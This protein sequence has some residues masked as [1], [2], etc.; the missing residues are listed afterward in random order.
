MMQTDRWITI[1]KKLDSYPWKTVAW[2]G[3]SCK[4]GVLKRLHQ[5]LANVPL[6]P[7][8]LLCLICADY[9]VGDIEIKFAVICSPSYL[10]KSTK[11]LLTCTRWLEVPQQMNELSVI[12]MGNTMSL[13]SSI[14]CHLNN[15]NIIHW[16]CCKRKQKKPN[17]SKSS[18]NAPRLNVVPMIRYWQMWVNV[19]RLLLR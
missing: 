2:W 16:H 18:L 11:R 1:G 19:H 8:E 4:L 9:A 12:I 17:I 3:R 10:R 7:I 15:L 5:E 14:Q 6:A 13:G